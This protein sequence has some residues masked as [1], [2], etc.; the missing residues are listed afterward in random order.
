MLIKRPDVVPKLLLPRL[1]PYRDP[2]TEPPIDCERRYREI[3][4]KRFADGEMPPVGTLCGIESIPNRIEVPEFIR[5][6]INIEFGIYV[7]ENPPSKV[8][9]LIKTLIGFVL[10][11]S[12][13]ALL[14]NI[15]KCDDPF[16]SVF[17]YGASLGIVILGSLKSP[18]ERLSEYYRLV[19]RV[20]SFE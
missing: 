8:E 9:L 15:T 4:L 1:H 13:G 6:Y 3:F 20:K 16:S 19:D 2:I 18:L 11:C 5:L 7:S 17:L 12:T 10:G 14:C